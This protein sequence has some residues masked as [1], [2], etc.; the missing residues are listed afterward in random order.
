[1]GESTREWTVP[2]SPA[3]QAAAS[4]GEH[5]TC[6]AKQALGPDTMMIIGPFTGF[7]WAMFAIHCVYRGLMGLW[8]SIYYQLFVSKLVF[9][10]GCL[11]FGFTASLIAAIVCS[12]LLLLGLASTV[13]FTLLGFVLMVPLEKLDWGHIDRAIIFC[14]CN[15]PFSYSAF[16]LALV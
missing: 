15:I 6:K 14:W 1:M 5:L 13:I 10:F 8:G 11:I 4:D 12:V 9:F 2:E 16:P 3:A 7:F